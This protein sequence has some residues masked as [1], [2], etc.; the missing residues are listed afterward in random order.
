MDA[1]YI[2]FNKHKKQE[3]TLNYR[4]CV[5]DAV[6]NASKELGRAVPKELVYKFCKPLLHEDTKLDKIIPCVTHLLKFTM[7][8]S[9]FG[10]KIG[11]IK[12]S[13][14]RCTD[15]NIRIITSNLNDKTTRETI[16]NHAFVHRACPIPGSRRKHIGALI[17][18]REGEPVLLIQQS[19]VSSHNSARSV[20]VKYLGGNSNLELRITSI[21]KVELRN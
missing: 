8:M 3:R 13:L 14:L 4:S 11:R 1:G 7:D 17:D 12:A 6:I 9:T 10:N 16:Y 2:L 21:I 15:R 5:Q 19:D 20:Y 18:N